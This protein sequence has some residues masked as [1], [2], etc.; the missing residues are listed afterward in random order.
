MS[1]LINKK[2]QK[3]CDFVLTF[4]LFDKLGFNKTNNKT[5]EEAEDIKT[6]KNGRL[7]AMYHPYKKN[8]VIVRLV[9]A[10]ENQWIKERNSEVYHQIPTGYFWAESLKGSD[11]STEWGPVPVILIKGTPVMFISPFY[12]IKSSKILEE[13]I[14]MKLKVNERLLNFSLI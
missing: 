6:N 9:T 11:D 13:K 3:F 5:D 14:S 10:T 7:V 12:L 2:G 4:N 8:T 1:P